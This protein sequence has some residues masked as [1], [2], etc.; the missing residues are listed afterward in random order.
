M[1]QLGPF[2]DVEPHPSRVS[3][4]LNSGHGRALVRWLSARLGSR[5]SFD[6]IVGV[7]QEHLRNPKA[8]AL[9]V[10]KL[11]ARSILVGCATG[12]STGLVPLR[13]LPT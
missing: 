8:K 10:L 3:L 9:A 5:R 7:Q 12:M 4:S 2:S 11:M 6:H 13:I 1:S